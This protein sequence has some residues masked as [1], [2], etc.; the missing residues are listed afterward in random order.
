MDQ[1]LRAFMSK[2]D[3]EESDPDAA[4]AS[5]EDR[6]IATYFR[7]IATHPGAFDL[8]DD[9]AAIS[10]PKVRRRSAFCCQSGC[11]PACRPIGSNRLRAGCVRMPSTIAVRCSAAI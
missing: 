7:P 11:R 3:G 1:A 6:L 9:A 5:A 8:T 2:H 10:P 4:E